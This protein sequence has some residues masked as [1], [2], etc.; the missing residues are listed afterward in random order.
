MK[1]N[2]GDTMNR[3]YSLLE[4]KSV[5]EET[6]TIEGM[7]TTPSTDLYDD[8]VEPLG[9][10]FKLPLPLL[11]QHKAGEPIGHVIKAVPTDKGIRVSAQI[12]RSDEP[13][14]LKDRLDEAWQSIKTGLV[15]GLSIGF[16]PIEKAEI[17]GSWGYRYIKW[18]WLELSAVTIPANIEA[19][20]STVK[21]YDRRG[22]LG[23]RSLKPPTPQEPSGGRRIPG[24][25]P[26]GARS[27]RGT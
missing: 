17:E 2:G 13:G 25:L 1:P 15:R 3:A 11:W 4:I 21:S 19:S 8:I 16:K 18:L 10:Q 24:L 7:A 27:I 12:A 22:A 26:K 23:A 5:D 14:K 6:R 9:A 20:I